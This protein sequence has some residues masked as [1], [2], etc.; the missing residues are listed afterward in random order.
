[1]SLHYAAKRKH[2]SRVRGGDYDF[3]VLETLWTMCRTRV[4]AGSSGMTG[5]SFSCSLNLHGTRSKTQEEEKRE[6]RTMKS[7]R[8]LKDLS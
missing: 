3:D 6:K 5:P 8:D 1:M 4:K 7:T 2:S